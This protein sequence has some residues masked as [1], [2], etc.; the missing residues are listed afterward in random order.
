MKIVV[1]TNVLIS[2]LGWQKSEHHLLRSVFQ[3]EN[4]LYM[5]PQIL[6]EFIQ[7]SERKKFNFSPDEIEEFVTSLIES[8]EMV[9]PREKINT[10]KKDPTDNMFLECAV[11][12]GVDH[13]ISGDRHLLELKEFRGITIIYAS[14]LLKRMDIVNGEN[15]DDPCGL[16]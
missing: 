9:I 3:G 14:S 2:A 7:V 6:E 4:I 1:D 10:V 15:L 13:I 8:C 12:G 16:I 5:S 11:E